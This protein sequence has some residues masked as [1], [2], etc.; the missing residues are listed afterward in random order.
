MADNLTSV[1]C[2]TCKQPIYGSPDTFTVLRQT[3]ATFHCLYGHPNAYTEGKS[4]EDM[5]REQ[6]EAERR[7]RQR[8][9]Q[10]IADGFR[11]RGRR[12]GAGE[13]RLRGLS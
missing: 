4:G 13:V 1:P 12:S 7:Q 6:L 9:E 3:R 5:L 11:A 2:Y 8:A 10:R